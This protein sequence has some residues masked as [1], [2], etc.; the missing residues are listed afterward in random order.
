MDEFTH[1]ITT[2]WLF[3]PTELPTV[4]CTVKAYEFFCP[5]CGQYLTSYSIYGSETC[6]YCNA[7]FNLEFT[8]EL[9]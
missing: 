2:D 4:K 1:K 9:P 8:D 7:E 5:T 3:P 6:L